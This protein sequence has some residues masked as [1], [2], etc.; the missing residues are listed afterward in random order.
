MAFG[1]REAVAS[2]LAHSW[3]RLLGPPGQAAFRQVLLASE[4]PRLTRQLLQDPESYVRASAVTA[5]GQLSS[6]GLHAAPAG[7]EQ[8]GVQ[9]VGGRGSHGHTAHIWPLS[10]YPG[11]NGSA[12][13]CGHSGAGAL[14]GTF[15]ESPLSLLAPLSRG[16]GHPHLTD[17]HVGGRRARRL[18]EAERTEPQTCMTA[19]SPRFSL[20]HPEP[21]S[22]SSASP[23]PSHP[24]TLS[25]RRAS[26]RSS[27][28]SSPQTRRA[29]PGGPSCRSSPSG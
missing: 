5:T 11:W 3:L 21:I 8:P 23:A 29:S 26:C 2:A 6:W 19:R 10:W 1:G 24:L 17:E 28:T 27:C 9:Q 25:S 12:A 18:R 16:H 22:R 15:P 4:V 7:P 14:L 20:L 13:S